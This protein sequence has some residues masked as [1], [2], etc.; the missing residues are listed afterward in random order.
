MDIII[1]ALF[2]PTPDWSSWQMDDVII[3]LIRGFLEVLSLPWH[4]GKEIK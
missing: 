2:V 1:I 4:A 3:G